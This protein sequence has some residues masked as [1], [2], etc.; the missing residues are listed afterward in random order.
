MAVKMS[1]RGFYAYIDRDVK[2]QIYT[3]R[4]NNVNSVSVFHGQTLQEVKD[5]FRALVTHIIENKKENSEI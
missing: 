1:Y 2:D 4:I 5:N 3:G